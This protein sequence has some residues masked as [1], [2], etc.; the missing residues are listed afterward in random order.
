MSVALL[1]DSFEMRIV[2]PA[3][4][5]LAFSGPASSIPLGQSFYRQWCPEDYT[6]FFRSRDI[7]TIVRLNKQVRARRQ[8]LQIFCC[9]KLDMKSCTMSAAAHQ[10]LLCR[11]HMTAGVS[12]PTASSIMSFTFQMVHAPPWLSCANFSTSW[13]RNQVRHL[14]ITAGH[15]VT[16]LLSRHSRLSWNTLGGA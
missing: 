8:H 6:A 14:P 2:Q 15:L 10:S 5:L 7:T 13:K 12:L 11:R 4:K 3:G 1:I 9:F 16:L